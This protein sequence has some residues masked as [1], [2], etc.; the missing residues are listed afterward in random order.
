MRTSRVTPITSSIFRNSRQYL[1]SNE[2]FVRL[3]QEGGGHHQFDHPQENRKQNK[4]KQKNSPIQKKV[5]N[6]SSKRLVVR[7]LQLDGDC[8]TEIQNSLIEHSEKIN[9]KRNK[10]TRIHIYRDSI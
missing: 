2:M 1:Q 7:G 6:K 10:K 3:M 5:L 9:S 8:V 4:E